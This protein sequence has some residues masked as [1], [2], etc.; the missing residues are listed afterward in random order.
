MSDTYNLSTNDLFV[1]TLVEK[2]ME[3]EKLVDEL[4]E[5]MDVE[6]FGKTKLLN[7]VFN[8]VGALEDE[9]NPLAK[10]IHGFMKSEAVQTDEQFVGFYE[11]IRRILKPYENRV[12]EFVKNN[13]TTI[14]ESEKPKPHE[15]E[16]MRKER[17]TAVDA[18]NGIRGLLEATA[19]VWFDDQGSTLLNVMEN[20]RGAVGKRGTL[21]PRLPKYQF[22]VNGTI[23]SDNKLSA[24]V[25]FLKSKVKDVKEVR[26]AIKAQLPNFDFE[27]PPREFEF[28]IAGAHVVAEMLVDDS[29]DEDDNDDGDEENEEL[30]DLVTETTN[31][32]TIFFDDDQDPNTDNDE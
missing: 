30:E 7:S 31:E 23:L 16:E 11:T 18:M 14:P 28:N 19:K 20:K 27:N 21:G 9:K 5:K 8:N 22:K 1:Q 3:S 4:D 26:E 15:I 32:D 17:K 25:T 13:V 6:S 24:I 10:I 2:W 12:N 29:P